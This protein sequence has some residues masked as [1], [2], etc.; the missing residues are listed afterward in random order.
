[1]KYRL[2]LQTTAGPIAG[3]PEEMTDEVVQTIR[4]VL[5]NLYDGDTTLLTV[6][7]NGIVNYVNPAHI[8][9]AGLMEVDDA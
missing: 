6:K 8:T 5:R 1:M 3:D 9:N 7:V 2:A 4:D